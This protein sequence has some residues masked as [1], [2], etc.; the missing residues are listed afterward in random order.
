[1]LHKKFKGPTGPNTPL[2]HASDAKMK[3]YA[4]RAKKVVE[5]RDRRAAADQDENVDENEVEQ[6]VKAAAKK[7]MADASKLAMQ[8]RS[9][10]SRKTVVGKVV[11]DG[12]KK[13]A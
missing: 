4:D 13:A 10:K 5:E 11:L 12:A 6:E 1:M 3:E 9:Q 2:A 7:R 8:K